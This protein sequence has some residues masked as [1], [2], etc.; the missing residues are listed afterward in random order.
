MVVPESYRFLEW[1]RVGKL[2]YLRPGLD[3]RRHKK[4]R[5]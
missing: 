2:H 4:G 3:S 5:H 1:D